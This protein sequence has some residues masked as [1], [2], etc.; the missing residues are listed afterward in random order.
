M[1]PGREKQEEPTLGQ[2]IL[3]VAKLGGYLDRKHD[4]PPGSEVL[5]RGMLKGEAYGEAWLAFSKSN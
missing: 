2:F 1:E 5:W 3:K 4:P